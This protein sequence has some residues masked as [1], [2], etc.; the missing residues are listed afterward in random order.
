MAASNGETAPADALQP[1]SHVIIPP[2]VIR[3]NIVKTADYCNRHGGDAE[4]KMLAR[5]RGQEKP[6]LPFVLPE[7][8]YYPY[9]K[10][11]LQLLREGKGPAAA[12]AQTGRDN[13]PKGPP[14]PPG[15]IFSARMPNISAKD[16]EILRLTALYTARIGENWLKELRSRETGNFQFDFLRANHSFFAYFR[17]LVDQYKT[18]LEEDN[19]VEERIEELQHN[20]KDRFHI[21]DR[22]KMRAAYVKY[23]IQQKEKEEKKNEDE[24]NEY[25]SIDWYDF[26]IIATVVFDDNEDTI[27]L[28]PP[29][30]LA[31][32]QS[33]SLEQKAMV[34]LS[35]K[36]IEE[37][38]PDEVP[39]Y[40]ATQPVP[41]MPG[42]PP[43]APPVQP[44][45]APMPPAPVD[46]RNSAPQREDEV[47]SRQAE[48]DRIAQAQAA[49]RGAP[50]AMRIKT[51]YVPRGKKVNVSTVVCPNC[52]QTFPP[53]EIEEHIRSKYRSAQIFG[54]IY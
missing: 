34:S 28:P 38:R 7:D 46:Y 47:R 2:K 24:R 21:L 49:A 42:Y 5:V 14:A 13:K 9:Y 22:A 6:T 27:E 37:A 51:D 4:E 32:L 35:S 53:E 36:R 25:L 54:S 20:I 11:Y 48:R 26:G 8:Q 33:A 18:L 41:P 1:P 45:Y 12:S 52:K 23:T 19:K 15:F 17:S 43:M 31:E 40:N 29:A 50:N 44:V 3:D 16:L 39:Y 30:N 10:W